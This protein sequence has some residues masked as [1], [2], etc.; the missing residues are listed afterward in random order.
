[1]TEAEAMEL[2]KVHTEPGRDPKLSEYELQRLLL[3]YVDDLGDYSDEAIKRAICDAW[4]LKVNKSSDYFD[5]SVNG[6][7]M[8]TNQMKQNC[9]ERARYYRRRLPVTVA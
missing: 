6:R 8:N 7:N 4:D 5:L 2:V 9:E 3:C 1:M